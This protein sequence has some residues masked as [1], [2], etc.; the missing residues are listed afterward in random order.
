MLPTTTRRSPGMPSCIGTETVDYGIVLEGEIILILDE[1]ETLVR[2]GER[3]PARHESRLGQ[4]LGTQLS[5]CV[6][7]DRRN[8]R[9][10]S[11]RGWLIRE[12]GPPVP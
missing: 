12:G 11:C 7:P 8:V 2:A 4:S 9:R 10:G 5:D 3:H 1:S 6:H